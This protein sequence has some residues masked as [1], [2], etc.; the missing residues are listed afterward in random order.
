MDAILKEY[1][2]AAVSVEFNS[3]FGIDASV[4]F[5]RR[6]TVIWGGNSKYY[7]KFYGCS[8]RAATDIA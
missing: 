8:A 1:R 7:D 3:N 2:P 5:S 6:S 4:S